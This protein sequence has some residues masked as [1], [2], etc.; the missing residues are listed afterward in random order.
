MSVVRDR[1][2]G[3]LGF[4]DATEVAVMD[5][6]IEIGQAQ[7]V[8]KG[9]ARV[10]NGTTGSRGHQWLGWGAPCRCR[11]RHHR[12]DRRDKGNLPRSS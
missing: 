3:G 1:N 12:P 6:E 2:D 7:R 9:S 4:L 10:Q 8:S 5:N 11:S